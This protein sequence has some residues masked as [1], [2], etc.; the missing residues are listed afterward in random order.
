MFECFR[1]SYRMTALFTSLVL[2][3]SVML[4]GLAKSA[5]HFFIIFGVLIREYYV[6]FIKVII[7]M[8]FK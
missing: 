7:H 6:L 1:F 4:L 5:S 2:A 3:L 8:L